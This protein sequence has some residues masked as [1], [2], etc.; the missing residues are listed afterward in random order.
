MALD[1][2]VENILES[3]RKDASQLIAIA[4][5]EKASILQQAEE[6]IAAKKLEQQKE[7]DETIRRLRQQEIS[8]AELEAKRIVLNVR[9]DVLDRSLRAP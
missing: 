2:V 9:K 3:A 5:K 7:L 8:S 1:K 6:S 4:E